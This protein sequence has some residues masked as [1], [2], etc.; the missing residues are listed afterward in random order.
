MVRKLWKKNNKLLLLPSDTTKLMSGEHCC[1][2]GETCVVFTG[3]ASNDWSGSGW[4]FNSTTTTGSGYATG[5]ISAVSEYQYAELTI[6]SSL[7]IGD[8][9]RIIIRYED[10]DNYI[11]A[12]VEQITASTTTLRLG[13]RISASDTIIASTTA[14]DAQGKKLTLCIVSD[15][16]WLYKLTASLGGVGVA[17]YS[18]GFSGLPT[19]T[20]A[21]IWSDISVTLSGWEFNQRGGECPSCF[22]ITNSCLQVCLDDILSR[23]YAVTFPFFSDFTHAS[24]NCPM[25]ENYANVTMIYEASPFQSCRW[26]NLINKDTGPPVV[27]NADYCHGSDG[28]CITFGVTRCLRTALTIFTNGSGNICFG[29]EVYAGA[30]YLGLYEWDSGVAYDGGNN[31]INCL[32]DPVNVTMTRKFTNSSNTICEWPDEVTL[33]GPV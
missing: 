22:E 21:G 31:R 19:G 25:C 8:K 30:L 15:A 24:V 7:S 18:S 13:T 28:T 32:E 14:G 17:D 26:L 10:E 33:L 6:D 12:E 16:F 11:Y 9:V 23:H 20:I 2:P 4:V 27:Y 5:N 29:L 1:C 3:F